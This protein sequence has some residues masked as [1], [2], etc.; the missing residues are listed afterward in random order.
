VVLFAIGSPEWL[1]GRWFL[2]GAVVTVVLW[3]AAEIYGFSKARLQL[4]NDPETP[5]GG[6]HV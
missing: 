1:D 4:Y 3:Q 2:A 5:E 6:T